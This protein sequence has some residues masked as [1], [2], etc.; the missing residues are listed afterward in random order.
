MSI[1]L[2][3]RTA[4]LSSA[5]LA[6][7][8]ALSPALAQTQG[9]AQPGPEDARF[10]DLAKRYLDGT[11]RLSP[12]TATQT[13]D[14]RFDSELDDLSAAGRKAALDFAKGILADLGRI[15]RAGLSR[16]NQVDAAILDNAL[17]YS[18]WTEEQLRNW[19]WDPLVYSQL[20]GGAVYG[21]MARDF[22][23]VEQ[24]L[25]DATARME[26]LPTL[27]R[28]MR[29]NIEVAKVPSIHAETVAKQNKGVL[30]LID[31]LVMPAAAKLPA[32]DRQRLDAAVATLRKAVEE[33][34]AWLDKTLVPGAKG[35][36]RISAELY[37][38][39]LA[40][41][42][43][44][45][46]DR[47]EIRRRAEAALTATRADMYKVAQG[48]LKG[49][50]G[51][52]SAPDNPTPEQQQAVIAAALELAYAD[53][54]ARDKVVAVAEKTLEDTTAFVRRK[55]LITLPDSPVKII[56]MPEFQRGVAVAY[57][58][59]PGPLEKHLATFYAV[60]PIPEDWT[61][62][63]VDSFL[64]EYN[65]RSIEELT[66]H[67]AMPGHFVQIAHANKHP[68]VLRAVLSSGPFVE[69]WAVYAERVMADE[70]YRDGDPLYRLIQQ[71]WYLRAI[72]NAILDQAI[73][74]DGMTREE[75]MKLMVET[76]FQQERE[77]AG[78]WV[79]AQ[80]SSSQLPTYFVGYQEHAD[81]R[82]EAEKRWGK[83]FALKRYHDTVLSFGSP[84]V[85]FA[86]ALMFGEAV[87]A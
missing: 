3:R 47:K 39:K 13:G 33:H 69:G 7:M 20:A 57:C 36:F 56:L 67:E 65:T 34:Q 21:L 16:E 62:E 18:I 58:D 66:V 70:G 79:R 75:A 50:A 31:E 14:H 45:P 55:D 76:T 71:K 53:R 24:R 59:S 26:K 30:S 52:P 2:S 32:A 5:A 15:D 46:L 63:Q 6:A 42:L 12:I 54:P 72:A 81:L 43:N 64:R 4:L 48:V 25:R 73:H 82:V 84:P 23:P 74:V 19:A 86:R 35:E 83:D 17:R 60:S 28:Q 8:A 80:L 49:R 78:K 51:A 9:V 61:A 37:D 68:S 29:E 11:F 27:F 87:K 22:A 85:R 40:F 44:S 10:A 77:A 38:R 1:R 41:A